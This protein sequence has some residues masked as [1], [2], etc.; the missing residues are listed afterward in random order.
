MDTN[1][2]D[3]LLGLDS[4]IKICVVMDVEKGLIEIRQ[5][6]R[7]NVQILPLNMV[8]MLQLVEN[9][10]CNEDE[11]SPNETLQLFGIRH[12]PLEK[13]NEGSV[14]QDDDDPLY[15]DEVCSDSFDDSNIKMEDVVDDGMNN[16][17]LLVQSKAIKDLWIMGW[18]FLYNKGPTKLCI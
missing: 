16:L 9:K 1:N 18:T 8:N 5:G 4:L 2:Y 7:N 17:F 3:F 13:V 14:V 12:W 10:G 6:P 15:D 11:G